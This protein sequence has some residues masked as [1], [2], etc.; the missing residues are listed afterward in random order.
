ML[1]TP[2]SQ[3]WSPHPRIAGC[4]ALVGW[5]L[6]LLLGEWITGVQTKDLDSTFKSSWLFPIKYIHVY[7]PSPRIPLN[8]KPYVTLKPHV[9]L[10]PNPS[11]FGPGSF[12]PDFVLAALAW[13]ERF[14][15]SGTL[16]MHMEATI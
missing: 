2:S 5:G 12:F 16:C 6:G 15:E 9:A 7:N 3:L 1:L 4:S 13:V 14:V 10:N 11:S 8:P